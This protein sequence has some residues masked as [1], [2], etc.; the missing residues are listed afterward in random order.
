MNKAP[1][2]VSAMDYIAAGNVFVN[3]V[4]GWLLVFK[5]ILLLPAT[6]YARFSAS[7]DAR[8]MENS[9]A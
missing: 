9:D 5:I 3:K 2:S 8:K 6:K 1:I 7:S 4:I